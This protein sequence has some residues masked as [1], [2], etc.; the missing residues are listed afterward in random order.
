MLP[1]DTSE[2]RRIWRE[3][4]ASNECSHQNYAHPEERPNCPCW[5]NWAIDRIVKLEQQVDGLHAT[6]PSNNREDILR[7][8]NELEASKARTRARIDQETQYRDERDRHFNRL[9]DMHKQIQSCVADLE[10]AQAPG[11][12]VVLDKNISLEEFLAVVR[13][14][15]IFRGERERSG[16]PREEIEAV[17]SDLYKLWQLAEAASR[18]IGVHLKEKDL[19]TIQ[20]YIVASVQMIKALQLEIQQ[21]DVSS[22][23]VMFLQQ[24]NREGARVI[25]EMG[26][27]LRGM[28]Q[29]NM[30]GVGVV[31]GNLSTAVGSINVAPPIDFK[32]FKEEIWGMYLGLFNSERN[33][34]III[35]DRNM[36]LPE[37]ESAPIRIDSENKTYMHK[38]ELA[39][40]LVR[41]ELDRFLKRV[42]EL[43]LYI[44][45]NN[46]PGSQPYWSGPVDDDHGRALHVHEAM[47][48][49]EGRGIKAQNELKLSRQYVEPAT[50]VAYKDE[51]EERLDRRYPI[52]RALQGSINNLT[53]RITI[54]R[55]VPPAWPEQHERDNS[56]F[57][58]KKSFDL[59]VLMLSR[60]EMEYLTIRVIQ[61][62]ETLNNY[63]H[64][65]PPQDYDMARIM[66]NEISVAHGAK[67]ACEAE[68]TRP[69]EIAPAPAYPGKILP[70]LP[71]YTPYGYQTIPI[72]PTGG[73]AKNNGNNKGNKGQNEGEASKDKK[74][75][76]TKVRGN[77]NKLE[78][79]LDKK[80]VKYDKMGRDSRKNFADA[81]NNASA[82]T[83]MQKEL[84][85]LHEYRKKLEDLFRKT[86]GNVDNIQGYKR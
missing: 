7:L 36:Q 54:F 25:N 49:A 48:A 22:D 4:K 85:K 65:V 8:Q 71:E 45:S 2:G 63:W 14:E 27:Q 67:V 28:W 73:D 11:Q 18:E 75:N 50:D 30:P 86:G 62:L 39:A 13:R 53:Q 3:Y 6:A 55:Q 51:L 21:K 81:P 80:K 78:K 42:W 44:R 43:F 56:A 58:P 1:P 17:R 19:F 72:L 40:Q 10:F 84:D 52:Y 12:K 5:S 31:P 70:P 79:E 66:S 33:L 24:R 74:D 69:S 20:G 77:I 23:Y 32:S 41:N 29:G 26:E 64:L 59:L 83:K 38:W 47:K 35:M 61:L 46:V 37:W 60:I 9:L 34:S 82:D 57:V 76:N 16:I 15:L 68:L